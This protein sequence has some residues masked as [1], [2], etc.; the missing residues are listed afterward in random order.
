MAVTVGNRQLQATSPVGR[1]SLRDTTQRVTSY[2]QIAYDGAV[3]FIEARTFTAHVADYLEDDEY[4]ALQTLLAHYPEAG[5]VVPGTGGFRKLRWADP[6]RGKGRRG[7]PQSDLLLPPERC[8]DLADD[9]LQQ[10]RRVGPERGRETC[11]E[12][13]SRGGT[14]PAICSPCS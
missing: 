9:P 5:D 12:V 11:A 8:P 2:T 4:W 6:V 13:G 7:G 14:G 10:R 3:E 1:R